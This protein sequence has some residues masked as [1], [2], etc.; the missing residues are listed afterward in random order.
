M[1]RRAI[2]VGFTLRG[3]PVLKLYDDKRILWS[4][5]QAYSNL[6]RVSGMN[7]SPKAI[8]SVE[9]CFKLFLVPL[10]LE[11]DLSKKLHKFRDN[12]NNLDS[13]K[14]YFL[15]EIIGGK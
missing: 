1:T 10:I 13:C 6:L 12:N 5:G 15:P 8:L 11:S 7:D 2:V 4:Y 14:W 3:M 9:I